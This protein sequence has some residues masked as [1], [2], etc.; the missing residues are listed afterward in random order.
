MRH[1]RIL[2]VDD[3][4][5]LRDFLKLVFAN[6]GYNV[7]TARDGL[8]ALGLVEDKDVDVVLSDLMMPGMDGVELFR[9]LRRR[10]STIPFIMMSADEMGAEAARDLKSVAFVHKLAGP[11]EIVAAVSAAA[12]SRVPA[13]AI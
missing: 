7:L 5:P 4:E 12:D 13:L 9:A 2:V 1:T 10:R 11:A 3:S 6:E 8:E